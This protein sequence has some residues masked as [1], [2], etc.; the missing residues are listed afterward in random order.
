MKNRIVQSILIASALCTAPV[1]LQAQLGQFSL[2]GHTFQLHGFASQG[3]A[4][5]NQNNFLTMQ[6]SKGSFA[7]TD[8]GLNLS[9][10]LTD[11]F[12]VGAQGYLRNVG[13]LGGGRLS[14]DWAF[15]DYRFADWFGIRAGKVKT[16]L[17][18]FND[19]QDAESLHTWALLPQSVYPLD[20]RSSTI[21]HVGGD[22]YGQLALRKA[23][24]IDYTVYGG[25]RPNDRRSGYY[26]NTQDTGVPI[27][28][29][30]GKIVGSDVRWNTPVAGLMAG[31]SFLDEMDHINGT[32]I[33]AGNA[34]YLL[35]SSPLHMTSAY[36]DY[37][38]GKLRVNGEFRRNKKVERFNL[39]GNQ[40]A[41]N[42]SDKG[43]FVTGAYR[44]TRQL[45]LGAYHSHYRVDVPQTAD[46]AGNHLFDTT[47]T[48]RYDLTRWWN[49]KVEGHF[50]DGHG[51]L[52][53]AHGFYLRSNPTGIGPTT[54]LLVIRT[55]FYF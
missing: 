38:R 29:F 43:W 26:F 4:V 37:S 55:G 40:S 51:D 7:F 41:L 11:K 32:Y 31:M 49:V 22:I 34:P 53:S 35:D 28:T 45:E 27:R 5:S 6:T 14:L 2:E 23:G 48:A 33:A 16:P 52:Y 8:G 12:R 1:V 13:Q 3:Y 20:L 24:S 30:T 44:V 25:A 36:V 9:T 39:F 54:N 10:S 42:F 50:M 17:G 21:A 18:L 46:P 47:L 15:G 19:T